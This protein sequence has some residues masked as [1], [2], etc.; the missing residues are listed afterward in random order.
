MLYMNKQKCHI[1]QYTYTLNKFKKLA[2][3]WMTDVSV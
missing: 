2:Q 1:V 3:L